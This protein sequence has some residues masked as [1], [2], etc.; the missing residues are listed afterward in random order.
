MRLISRAQYLSESVD[1]MRQQDYDATHLVKAV[2][3]FDLN[4]KAY[5]WVNIGGRQRRIT[6]ANKDDAIQWFAEW[7]APHIDALGSS[8]KVLVPI[9][10]SEVT[11]TSP[12]SFR[13]AQIAQAISNQCTSA[14]VVAPILR[15][16]TRMVPSRSGGPRD[17]RVLYDQLM[18]NGNLPD[19]DVILIDDVI[20]GGGHLVAAAWRVEDQ[21]R[22]VLLA[23]CCG[24]AMHQQTTDPFQISEENLDLAR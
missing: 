18:M 5:T 2:K 3:G 6:D 11:G 8:A 15:W 1:G 24:R 14:T 16:R 9:P 12:A 7:A 4:P 22:R 23:V 21:G 20:T 10:G 19:G 13:T 17:K